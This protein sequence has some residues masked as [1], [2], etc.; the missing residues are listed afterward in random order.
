[1]DINNL[2]N[3][4]PNRKSVPKSRGKRCECLGN[5]KHRKSGAHKISLV[6]WLLKW[7]I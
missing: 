2:R 3:Y 4:F 6:K 7:D 5:K 1:M